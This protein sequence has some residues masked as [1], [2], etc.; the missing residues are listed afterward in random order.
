MS[1]QADFVER[2]YAVRERAPSTDAGDGGAK[3]SV[4]PEVE[5]MQQQHQQEEEQGQASSRPE[6]VPLSEEEE[7]RRRKVR[8]I[9]L[10]NVSAHVVV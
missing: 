9:Q 6:E 10:E 8:R 7:A 3:P 4:P 5:Q 1:C 2:A